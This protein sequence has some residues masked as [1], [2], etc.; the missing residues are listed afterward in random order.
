MEKCI[1]IGYPEGYKGWK[2]YIPST[3]CTIISERAEF[4]EN[5]FPMKNK[6]TPKISASPNSSI[7]YTNAEQTEEEILP[8]SNSGGNQVNPMTLDS[9]TS[10]ETAPEEVATNPPCT[11]TIGIG[12]A[13]PRY[14]VTGLT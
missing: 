8:P 7:T 1:F 9:E 2:F 4:D 5:Q 11:E 13:G 3:Q 12:S 6:Q 14:P 10:P